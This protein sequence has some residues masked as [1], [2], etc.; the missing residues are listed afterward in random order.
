[1]RGERLSGVDERR[2]II[3]SCWYLFA[4]ARRV[5][6]HPGAATIHPGALAVARAVPQNRCMQKKKLV[7]LATAAGLALAILALL[8]VLQTTSTEQ[9]G[10]GAD[11]GAPSAPFDGFS[12]PWGAPDSAGPGAESAADGARP[13]EAFPV[14]LADV[15]VALPDN[16]YWRLFAPTDDPAV[17]AEREKEQAEWNQ[18]YGR[19]LSGEA[20]EAEI[21]RYIEYRRQLSEDQL[22]LLAHILKKYGDRL[23][24]RDRGLLELGVQMHRARLKQ[25]PRDRE[26][27]MQR[28]LE[29]DE[30]RAAWQAQR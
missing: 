24:A 8:V 25:L 3:S 28:K 20:S 19:T 9:T 12:T 13:G 29:Q 18:V 5:S 2:R 6:V 4:K 27:A 10:G 23:P 16:S 21:D 30:K 7:F 14:D 26:L 17:Q 15:K 11:A 1:M 22:E